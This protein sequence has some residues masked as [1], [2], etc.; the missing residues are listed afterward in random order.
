MGAYHISLDQEGQREIIPLQAFGREIRN[1]SE[2]KGWV[3]FTIN[4]KPDPL[5]GMGIFLVGI[6]EVASLFEDFIDQLLLVS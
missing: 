2:N 3:F 6:Q 5:T 1:T 4:V